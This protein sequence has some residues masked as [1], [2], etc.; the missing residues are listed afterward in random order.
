MVLHSREFSVCPGTKTLRRW[1]GRVCFLR[2]FLT[3]DE[4][5]PDVSD[6]GLLLSLNDWLAPYL[7]KM[8]RLSHLVRVDLKGALF[9]MLSYQQ[10]K[11]L[12]ALAPTHLAVPSGSR[13]PI[14]Y[15]NPVPV[16]AVRLQEMFGLSQTPAVV[17]GRQPLLIHLLSAGRSPGA[18][19]PGS[20]GFLGDG[21]S[22]GEKRTQGPIPQTLLA[23]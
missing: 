12:D 7:V 21:L 3:E 18:D 8:D 19:H 17:G 15:G 20:G 6:E 23:R 16:L 9:S 5:W 1:Q 11:A 10:H 13:I 22:S 2:R 4:S 14:D